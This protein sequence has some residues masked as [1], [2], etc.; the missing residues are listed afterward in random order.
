MENMEE[1][2]ETALT[3]QPGTVIYMNVPPTKE[4]NGI[5]TAGFVISLICMLFSWVPVLSWVL[6]V[7]GLILSFVGIFKKPRGLAIAGL[8]IS[9]FDLIVILVVVSAIAALLAALI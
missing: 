5:G 2:N 4:S 9:C 8:I 3:N 6:W 7:I 1:H